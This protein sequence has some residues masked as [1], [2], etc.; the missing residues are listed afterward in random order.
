M[1]KITLLT[2]LIT[3]GADEMADEK[4]EYPRLNVTFFSVEE[5]EHKIFILLKIQQCN[6]YI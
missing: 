2:F 5:H 6:L 1:I 3:K 4:A